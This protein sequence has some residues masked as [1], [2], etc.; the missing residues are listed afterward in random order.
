VALSPAVSRSSSA[1]GLTCRGSSDPS[2]DLHSRPPPTLLLTLSHTHAHSH[3]TH[4]T[5]DSPSYPGRNKVDS[6]TKRLLQYWASGGSFTR[7]FPKSS[8]QRFS[9][10]HA[11]RENQTQSIGTRSD[12][13]RWAGGKLTR[14]P[15]LFLRNVITYS[16]LFYCVIPGAQGYPPESTGNLPRRDGRAVDLCFGFVGF[17]TSNGQQ[18]SILRVD[19]VLFLKVRLPVACWEPRIAQKYKGE[20]LAVA[21]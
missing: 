15:G 20:A 4:N 5:T 8:F 12:L 11:L 13:P 19:Y 9:F 14:S 10:L 6:S 2:N 17:P 7:T 16:G 3:T 1:E 18:R 21:N